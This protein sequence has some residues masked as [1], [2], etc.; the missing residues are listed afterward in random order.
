M[1]IENLTISQKR[2]VDFENRMEADKFYKLKE[3][4]KNRKESAKKYNDYKPRIDNYYR[5][6]LEEAIGIQ[7]TKNLSDD[8][9]KKWKVLIDKAFDDIG[10]QEIEYKN[11]LI[12]DSERVQ[13]DE[14][15]RSGEHPEDLNKK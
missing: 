5:V 4:V 3:V 6:I 10:K 2:D 11:M 8:E 7:E 13:G 1:N 12:L 15:K 14:E 9:S